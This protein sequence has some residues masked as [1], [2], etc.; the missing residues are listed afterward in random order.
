MPTA[1]FPILPFLK[2]IALITAL[3]F[4]STSLPAQNQGGGAG[5]NSDKDDPLPK[6]SKLLFWRLHL[7]AGTV[8]LDLTKVTTVAQHE[9]ISDELF[10]VTELN[11][12]TISDLLIRLY[13][14]EKYIP[15]KGVSSEVIKGA[16]DRL[17]EKAELAAETAGIEPI[18]RQ[19]HKNY[20]TTTHARTVEYRLL[21]KDD[22]TKIREHIETAWLTQQS[23]T[24][25]I[26]ETTR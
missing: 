20:P 25:E 13:Y 19:V 11:I 9:Y 14:L 3:A 16:A 15:L 23:G 1:H 17:Q 22:L 24:C 7:P 6:D 2:T 21:H 18:W 4:A 10:R 5:N 26:P 12:A 8:T